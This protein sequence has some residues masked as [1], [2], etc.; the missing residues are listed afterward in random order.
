MTKIL[1]YL[2]AHVPAQLSSSLLRN[3]GSRMV[4]NY[5]LLLW[6]PFIF[7]WSINVK[8]GGSFR[9]SAM[10]TRL[11]K[12]TLFEKAAFSAPRRSE[13]VS[14][15][16]IVTSK[17]LRIDPD[18]G[19]LWSAEGLSDSPFPNAEGSKK[20]AFKKGLFPRPVMMRLMTQSSHTVFN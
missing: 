15:I 7:S 9:H 12:K 11:R 14:L 5:Q 17:V 8:R 16:K 20:G 6:T 18:F 1:Q 3:M 19:C 13:T 10:M 2:M 4:P